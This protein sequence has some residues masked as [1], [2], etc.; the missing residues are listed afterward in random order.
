MAQAARPRR[1][2]PPATFTITFTLGEDAYHVVPL[3]PDPGVAVVAFRFMKQTGGRE[4]YD[5]RLDPAGYAEC[6]CPGHQR[7]GTACKHLRTLLAAK[8]LPRSSV[9]PA[10]RSLG[11]AA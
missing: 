11:G 5:V 1:S 9:R 8:M 7:W 6:D 2:R 3:D 10:A 4:V